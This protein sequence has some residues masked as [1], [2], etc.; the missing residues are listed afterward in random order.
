VHQFRM[1]GPVPLLPHYGFG[2]E[3]DKLIFQIFVLLRCYFTLRNNPEER[4]PRAQRGE[5]LKF[6]ILY[7]EANVSYF[8]CSLNKTV[9]ETEQHNK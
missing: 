2:L 5:N 7:L 9:S 6:I 4:R 8:V 1:C 3:R